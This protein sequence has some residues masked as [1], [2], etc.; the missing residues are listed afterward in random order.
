MFFF[1]G[2]VAVVFEPV[3]DEVVEFFPGIKIL[4]STL[5]TIVINTIIDII[6]AT[7]MVMNW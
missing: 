6:P 2:V 7:I 3:E 1:D 4:I 5:V